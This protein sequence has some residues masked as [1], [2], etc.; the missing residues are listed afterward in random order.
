MMRTALLRMSRSKPL[1]RWVKRR[2]FARKAV[3]RFMPGEALDDAL[4]AAGRL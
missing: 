4:E 2:T 1:E 3:A